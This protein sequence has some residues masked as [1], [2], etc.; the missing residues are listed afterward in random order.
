MSQWSHTEWTH[1]GTQ[2]THIIHLLVTFQ[3]LPATLLCS[4]L[5]SLFL[6]KT[7]MFHSRRMLCCLLTD[8]YIWTEERAIV[9]VDKDRTTNSPFPPSSLP[10][11][12]LPGLPSPSMDWSS[13][14]C[15]CFPP[16]DQPTNQR[17]ACSGRALWLVESRG[18][19]GSSWHT[20]QSCHSE[21]EESCTL[22][23]KAKSSE[24]LSQV[25]SSSSSSTLYP[26]SL[27]VNTY[28]CLK[29]SG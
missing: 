24:S 21:Q 16:V 12:W 5:D 25:T 6:N 19:G 2:R 29:S 7:F 27:F 28:R 8:R 3:F 9:V 26:C 15:N 10:T 13:C 11:T 14:S 20:W 1:S 18:S 4:T 17:P 23:S 22:V